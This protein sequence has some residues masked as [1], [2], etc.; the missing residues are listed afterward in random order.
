MPTDNLMTFAITCDRLQ[1]KVENGK[2]IWATLMYGSQRVS[3][4]E[5]QSRCDVEDHFE[6]EDPFSTFVREDPDSGCYRTDLPTGTVYFIQTAGFEYFFTQD[7]SIPSYFENL[8]EIV[9]ETARNNCEGRIILPPNNALA[10]GSFGHESEAIRIAPDLELIQGENSRYRLLAEDGSV[11][12]AAMVQNGRVETTFAT[13][14]YRDQGLEERLVDRIQSLI[15]AKPK[16]QARRD[17]DATD[18]EP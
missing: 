8:S 1:F 13:M 4:S 12:A 9:H 17:F 5:L 6:E 10:N 7:G 2:E 18:M 11:M 15:S 3:P 16:R 14:R